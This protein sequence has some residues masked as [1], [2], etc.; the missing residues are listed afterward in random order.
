MYKV[1]NQPFFVGNMQTKCNYSWEMGDE[2][3]QHCSLIKFI[4]KL[5]IKT[6]DLDDEN[7]IGCYLKGGF[8]QNCHGESFFHIWDCEKDFASQ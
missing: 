2:N 7:E 6:L 5:S 3:I 8:Q 4:K 1:I